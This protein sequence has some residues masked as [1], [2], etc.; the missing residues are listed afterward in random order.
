LNRLYAYTFGCNV[1]EAEKPISEYESLGAFFCRN[2]K[3]GARPIDTSA[4]MVC[5]V[6]GRLLHY[7]EID[8]GSRIE[9]VCFREHRA[10]IGKVIIILYR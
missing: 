3:A 9:Q 2:L 1:E 5:P 4:Q 6:D 10:P 7:G 8:E